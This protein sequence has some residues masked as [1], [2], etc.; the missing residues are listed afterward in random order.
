ML[1]EESLSAEEHKILT[2]YTLSLYNK[3]KYNITFLVGENCPVNK[4]LANRLEVDFI[5]YGS[6]RF[7]LAINL[8]LN[9]HTSQIEKIDKLRSKLKNIKNS[10]NIRTKTHLRPITRNKTRCFNL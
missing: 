6:H 7:N 4:D 8:I 5:G 9:N 3:T 2:K 10:A 1:N